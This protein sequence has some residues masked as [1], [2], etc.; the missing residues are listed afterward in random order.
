MG[1]D[2]ARVKTNRRILN[3]SAVV[4]NYNGEEYLVDCLRSV[5][6]QEGIDEVI[7][8]DDASTDRSV[9][10]AREAFPNVTFIEFDRNGGPCVARN[11]GMRAARNR[12]VLAVDNDAVLTEG[13]VPKLKAALE[14]RADASIAQVRSV[15]HDEPDRVHYDGGAFH[16]VGLLSLRNFYRPLAEAEGEGVI[17]ADAL[18]GICALMDRDVVL[19]AGGYDEEFFY[20]AEDYE[21]AYRLRVFGHR[22]LS[23]ED[24]I[25]LHRGGTAGLS[26]RGGGYPSRRAR[27]HSCNRWR[28]LAK[29]YSARTLLAILPGLALYEL[30]WLAFMTK[31]RL[32]GSHAAGKLDFARGL[33]GVLRS[34]RA[35]QSRRRTRDRDLLVGG[36]LTFSPSLVASGP[37]RLAAAWLDA[38][39][40]A[41]WIIARPFVG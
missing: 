40:R 8:V 14:D 11:A 13:V 32:L 36:P 33:K 28:I 22:L 5:V 24:A 39:L 38:T 16:Y 19:S 35:I 1:Y 34:R 25:V 23:V 7:V 6:D 17:D 21:L 3:I 12:W 26:F 2:P 41:W 30:V 27:L 18:I 37:G 31:Q 10:L 15:I 4:C 29:C 9:A 20:L